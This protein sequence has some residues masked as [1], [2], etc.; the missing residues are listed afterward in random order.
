MERKNITTIRKW[1]E[2]IPRDYPRGSIIIQ[3]LTYHSWPYPAL[4]FKRG[5][6]AAI[7]LFFTIMDIP[8][9]FLG[10]TEGDVF[11]EKSTHIFSYEHSKPSIT[12]QTPRINRVDSS[13]LTMRMDELGYGFN[14]GLI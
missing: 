6:W 11:R 2:M 9:T 7:D 10:E 13:I 12:K 4:I 14:T 1:L 3:S 8:M 5:T